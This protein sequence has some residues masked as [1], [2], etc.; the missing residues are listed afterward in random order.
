MALGSFGQVFRSMSSGCKAPGC[1]MVGTMRMERRN[2]KNRKN[3]WKTNE[4]TLLKLNSVIYPRTLTRSKPL[5]LPGLG[6]QKG[7]IEYSQQ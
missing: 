3:I 5:G 4:K 1:E 6:L 2:G 7:R